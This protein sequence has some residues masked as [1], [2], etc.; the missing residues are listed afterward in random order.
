M[1]PKTVYFATGNMH[2]IREAQQEFER[3]N[4]EVVQFKVTRVEPQVADPVEIAIFSL[5]YLISTNKVQKPI[6]VEDAGL[7]IESLNG[8]PGAFSAYV[9]QT[10]G[11]S[12]ILKLMEGIG[13]RR[14]HFLSTVAYGSPRTKPVTFTGRVD[15]IIATESRGKGGFGFDPIFQ[16]Q[17]ESRTFAE[18][19]PEE[20]NKYSHRAIAFRKLAQWLSER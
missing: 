8:F 1:M 11:N 16:P 20:K 3:V 19:V 2:K 5:K 10:L 7:F 12:G 17:G 18:M 13:D 15:G 9:L 4:Y 6:F 14:A